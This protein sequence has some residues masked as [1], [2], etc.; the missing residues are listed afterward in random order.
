[1]ASVA[2]SRV[3]RHRETRDKAPAGAQVQKFRR[4]HPAG[5]FGYI[6]DTCGRV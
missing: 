3:P 5:V 1:M 6:R 4:L 2:L